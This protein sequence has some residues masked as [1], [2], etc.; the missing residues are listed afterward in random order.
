MWYHSKSDKR[1]NMTCRPIT[2]ES[3][4]NGNCGSIYFIR[5]IY[6]KCVPI[7][8]SAVLYFWPESDAMLDMSRVDSTVRE[9]I[10]HRQHQV[11]RWRSTKINAIN[12]SACIGPFSKRIVWQV[13]LLWKAVSLSSRSCS[14]WP[15]FK[16][17][18]VVGTKTVRGA[19]AANTDDRFGPK[20]VA[21]KPA[22][23]TKYTHTRIS[24]LL[25]FYLYTKHCGLCLYTKAGQSYF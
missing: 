14:C 9:I 7:A 11:H 8:I 13:N 2:S 10:R 15:T 23:E 21:C 22:N 20:I 5:T 3:G 19:S 12:L 24:L 4:R 6:G 25:C 1:A 16:K 17:A 18:S